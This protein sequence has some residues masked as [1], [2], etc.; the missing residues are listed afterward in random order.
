MFAR[1]L[2]FIVMFFVVG[3]LAGV[4]AVTGHAQSLAIP[5]DPANPKNA[6]QA[7]LLLPAGDAKAPALLIAPGDGYHRNLA[8]TAGLAQ[9]ATASGWV[10]LRFDWRYYSNNPSD[11]RPSR[12]F[13]TEQA[14]FE[15]ALAFLKKH[16]RV[17]ASR[18][19]IAG[20]SM[21]SIV[22]SRTFVADTTPKALLLLTPVCRSGGDAAK[23]YHR[24]LA[25]TR[26][27]I[28]VMGNRDGVCPLANLYNW[29][30]DGDPRIAVLTFPGNHSFL[31]GS[32][33]DSALT[34]RNQSNIDH[35]I[36]A[37]VHWLNE[38]IA[39]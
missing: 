22:A 17:D 3:I 23:N 24:V 30:K 19:V 27:V 11:G 18:I 16:P 35:A 1:T 28:V 34:A 4:L 10:T 32:D 25:D 15:A 2:H 7:D 20:K 5:V 36:N 33:K 21:G 8:L 37:A 29:A 39:K 6:L 9:S 12:D 38:I 31:V 26:P 14:D 13:I